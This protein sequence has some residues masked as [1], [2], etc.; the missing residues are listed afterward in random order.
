M[1]AIITN[2]QTILFWEIH[3]WLN[4]TGNTTYRSKIFGYEA[5]KNII[6]L[7][8][9]VLKKKTSCLIVI[10]HFMCF[11]INTSQERG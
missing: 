7:L 2:S 9:H 5:D 3:W 11:A 4:C 1:L 6:K 10:T 8:A